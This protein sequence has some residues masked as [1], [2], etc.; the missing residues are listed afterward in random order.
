MMQSTFTLQSMIARI[1]QPS[2]NSGLNL[3]KLAGFRPIQ[4]ES[5]WIRLESGWI[6]P[7]LA[8]FQPYNQ[9]PV[10]LGQSDLAVIQLVQTESG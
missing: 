4:Q 6:R 10:V 5:S 3:A 8:R 2:P 7:D 1:R 9:S